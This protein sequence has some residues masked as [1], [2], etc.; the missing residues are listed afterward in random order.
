[1]FAKLCLSFLFFPEQ[2]SDDFENPKQH[3]I[4]A[5]IVYKHLHNSVLLI[6]SNNI[7]LSRFLIVIYI[8]Y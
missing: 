8:Y 5:L 7:P 1:M 3:Y 2:K 6:D 4:S